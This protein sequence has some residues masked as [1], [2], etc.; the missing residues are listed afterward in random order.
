MEASPAE[1]PESADSSE[2]KLIKIKVKT[3]GQAS[4]DLEVESTVSFFVP[5]TITCMKLKR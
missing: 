5:F 3:L 1:P 2:A 4:Y